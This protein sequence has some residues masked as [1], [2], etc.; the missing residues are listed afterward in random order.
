MP[1]HSSYN[2]LKSSYINQTYTVDS[3]VIFMHTSVDQM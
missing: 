3:L 2:Q 1:I